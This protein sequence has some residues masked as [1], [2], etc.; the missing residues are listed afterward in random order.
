MLIQIF[1]RNITDKDKEIIYKMMNSIDVKNF[2]MCDIASND[3]KVFQHESTIPVIT[4]ALGGIVYRYIQQRIPLMYSFP[5]IEQL[6]PLPEN[7]SFR[8]DAWK[9]LQEIQK[10]IK[11]GIVSTMVP[12]WEYASTEWG[13]KKICIYRDKRPTDISADLYISKTECEL[14]IELKKIFGVESLNLEG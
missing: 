2:E 1:C 7:L 3:I 12:E 8:Q 9:K 11:T 6:Y 10:I 14:L 5:A 13:K 4:I